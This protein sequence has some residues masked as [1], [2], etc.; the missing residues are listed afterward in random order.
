[1]QA[2]SF[3]NNCTC[4]VLQIFVHNAHVQF[5][6]HSVCSNGQARWLSKW[7]SVYSSSYDTIMYQLL[8]WIWSMYTER[9]ENVIY[10][11]LS[12]HF[13]SH[14][15]LACNSFKSSLLT[16]TGF[17]SKCN[18]STIILSQTLCVT[19]TMVVPKIYVSLYSYAITKICLTFRHKD[20]HIW[21][22]Y[23]SLVPRPD[24]P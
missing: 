1:M 24:R 4:E 2:R 17:T 21:H 18:H 9:A 14:H 7:L 13:S 16:Q 19:S 15:S 22:V 12:M 8:L 11:V 3:E 5:R 10:S 20:V 6:S 23:I